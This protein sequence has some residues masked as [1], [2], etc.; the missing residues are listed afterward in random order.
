MRLS[1][2]VVVA[3]CVACQTV[4]TPTPLPSP[5]PVPTTTY[6]PLPTSTPRVTPTPTPTRTVAEEQTRIKLTRAAHTARPPTR[7]RYRPT[8]TSPSMDSRTRAAC[9]DFQRAVQEGLDAGIPANVLVGVLMRELGISER[10]V[11]KL[12]TDCMV[13]LEGR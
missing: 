3:L 10:E 4:D 2:I 13:A 9:R 5:V 1:V 6:T 11:R 12:I 8:P 7:I